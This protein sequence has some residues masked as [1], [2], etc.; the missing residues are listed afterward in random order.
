MLVPQTNMSPWQ[1]E[2]IEIME[3]VF[4]MRSV[5]GTAAVQSLSA[6]AVRRWQLRRE[7]V[8]EPRGRGTSAVGSRHQATAVKK[9]LWALVRV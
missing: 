8:R 1:K 3:A 9:R 6:V 2:N 4:S 5:P 7:T